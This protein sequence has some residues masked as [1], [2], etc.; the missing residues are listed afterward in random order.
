MSE[1][2]RRGWL[3][4]LAGAL[5]AI[6]FLAGILGLTQGLS[7]RDSLLAVLG[8]LI[9]SWAA[10]DYRRFRRGTPESE[11]EGGRTIE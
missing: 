4:G 6:I 8:F 11:V 9:M 5:G 2:Q 3:H 7:L 10:L 1:P